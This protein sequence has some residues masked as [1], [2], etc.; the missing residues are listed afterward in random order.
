MLS[1]RANFQIN[2]MQPNNGVVTIDFTKN[3]DKL[4]LPLFYK[5]RKCNTR[6]VVNYGGAG[7][8]KSYSQHQLELINI[9]QADKD[10]LLLRKHGTSIQD[11]SYALFQNIALEWGIHHLFEWAFSNAKRQ[12]TV[13]H[14]GRKIV[15]KGLDDTEKIKSIAGIK[16]IVIEEASEITLKDFMEVTRRARGADGIQ[17]TLLLN[18]VSEKHWIKAH[19]VDE[20]GTWHSKTSIFHTTYLDNPFLTEDDIQALMDLKRVDYNHYRIYALGEWGIEDKQGKFAWAFEESRHVAVGTIPY[21]PEHV[22][23]LSFDFNR[24]PMTCGAIQYYDGWI[25]VLKSFKL[26]NSDIYQM[27]DTLMATY[28]HAIYMV[29]GDATGQNKSALAKQDV[30]N[31][32]QVIKQKLEIGPSQIK[33]PSVNP[34]I[35][36]NKVLVN[37]ILQNENVLIDPSCKP[38]IFDLNYVE[39]DENN[40]IIKDRSSEKKEADSLDWFRYWININFDKYLRFKKI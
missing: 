35:S 19:L 4:F 12:I 32:Y 13:K 1:S 24:N 25:Y 16:R 15:M 26:K 39:I 5:L 20:T 30:N 34:D 7:S 37:A 31:F 38:L 8:G 10:T 21:N 27:C 22:L 18:P 29:T 23:W 40:K 33:L 28:P 36:M 14:S 9:L 11:S 3:A 17:I 2:P 6:Y